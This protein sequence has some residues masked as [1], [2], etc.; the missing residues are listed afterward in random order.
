M[1]NVQIWYAD[2]NDM[3][4]EVADLINSLTS[5]FINDATVQA[6]LQDDQ[7]VDVVGQVWPVTVPYSGTDGLYQ[8]TV[9]K[10]V[11]VLDDAGYLLI[12]TASAPGGLDAE[13]RIKVGGETRNE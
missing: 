3:V 13:W 9:D 4:I 11:Q 2:G 7:G 8:V 10:A 12:V 5:A 1:A 6:T